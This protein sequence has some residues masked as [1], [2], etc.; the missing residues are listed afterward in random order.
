MVWRGTRWDC[1]RSC[2]IGLVA[3]V[4]CFYVPI[5]TAEKKKMFWVLLRIHVQQLSRA[6]SGYTGI[7][8]VQT[9][10]FRPG[11]NAG[12]RS[13]DAA[14]VRPHATRISVRRFLYWRSHIVGEE[15]TWGLMYPLNNRVNGF[16]IWLNE[17]EIHF[18]LSSI[19]QN[20]LFIASIYGK[21]TDE[22]LTFESI[23]SKPKWT[24]LLR[25]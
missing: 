14:H 20:W 6:W 9:T 23:E 2:R 11:D 16:A 17:A 22:I 3:G 5:A 12:L 4:F 25:G 21:L 1:E 7:S 18:D 10:F 24:T 8:S 15:I 19:I 13:Y